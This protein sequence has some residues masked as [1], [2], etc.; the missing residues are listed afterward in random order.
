LFKTIGVKTPVTIR[1][2]AFRQLN[3]IFLAI[4]ASLLC[5]C[6]ITSLHPLYED[7]DLVFEPKLLGIWKPDEA[8]PTESWTVEKASE[9]GYHLT[10]D[11]DNYSSLLTAHL[12]RFG[13]NYFLN[14]RISKSGMKEIRDM[15]GPYLGFLVPA[16]IFAKVTFSDAHLEAATLDV[17]KTREFLR[18]NPAALRYELIENDQIVVTASTKELQDFLLKTANDAGLF[19][20]AKK[21]KKVASP[22]DKSKKL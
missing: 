17:G 18:K 19:S 5:G 12:A 6:L 7:K 11:D 22:S 4:T 14:L 10:L 3:F 20:P 16:H 21:F 1:F 13:T 15:E 2:R 8:N 9:K